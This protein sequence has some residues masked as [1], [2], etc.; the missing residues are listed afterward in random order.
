MTEPVLDL[1]GTPSPRC[2]FGDD[3]E[4]AAEASHPTLPPKFSAVSQSGVPLRFKPR[5]M[6]FQRSLPDQKDV[7]PLTTDD[8]ANQL[9]AAPGSAHDLLDGHVFADEITEDNV[10]LFTPQISLILRSLGGCQKLRIYGGCADCNADLPHRLANGVK[11]GVA[12][13]FHQMPAVGDLIGMRQGLCSGLRIPAAAICC[14]SASQALTADRQS[15]ED[16]GYEH[17]G[18]WFHSGGMYNLVTGRRLRR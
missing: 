11:K 5:Q 3:T 7:G 9:S 10:C 17:D 1:F 4:T 14:C 6:R 8:T 12:G 13:V 18:R 2:P 15:S 16:S